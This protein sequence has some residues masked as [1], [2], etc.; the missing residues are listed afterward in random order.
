MAPE[1]ETEIAKL[2]ADVVMFDENNEL[3]HVHV[4]LVRRK[5]DPDVLALP[6]G[7]VHRRETFK[8]AAVREL[9]EETG[10]RVDSR[11]LVHI[12][13]YDD[14]DRNPH[15]RFITVAHATKTDTHVDRDA[16]GLPTLNPAPGESPALWVPVGDAL[17]EM[18]LF[19]DHG[20]ILRHALNAFYLN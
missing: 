9:R 13:V 2:A 11:R 3:G 6:G 10:M 12:G 14:P 19:T 7:K 8:E 20:T 4:L 5:E 17:G 18:T 16:D 1:L 15:G